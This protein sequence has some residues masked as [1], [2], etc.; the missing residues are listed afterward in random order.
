MLVTLR[1]KAPPRPGELHR[2]SGGNA[3][4]L[5]PLGHHGSELSLE[6]ADHLLHLIALLDGLVTLLVGHATLRVEPP[7]NLEQLVSL[8]AQPGNCLSILTRSPL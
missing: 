3:L 6:G 2:Q 4:G 7:Y 8:L 5:Q 1:L